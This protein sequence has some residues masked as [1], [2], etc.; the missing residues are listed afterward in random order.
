MTE[1]SLEENAIDFKGKKYVLVSSR[2]LYF[3]E[4]YP[5]GSITT[6]LV[7]PTD[8]DTVVMK[9]TVRP[10]DGQVFTCYSQATWG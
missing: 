5:D 9:A 8:A 6:E 7:S 3:N 1:K 4:T 10:K 2:V